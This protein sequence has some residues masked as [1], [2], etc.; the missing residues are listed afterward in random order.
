M[1]EHI[2]RTDEAAEDVG[3]R[4]RMRACLVGAKIIGRESVDDDHRIDVAPIACFAP[5]SAS[6]KTNEDETLSKRIVK[7]RGEAVHPRIDIDGIIH[8][9]T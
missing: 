7:K 8:R 2:G 1:G 5:C 3:M 9:L 4:Q 6:L